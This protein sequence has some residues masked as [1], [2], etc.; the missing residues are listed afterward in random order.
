MRKAEHDPFELPRC[1]AVEQRGECRCVLGPAEGQ[2]AGDGLARSRAEREHEN[3]VLD[4]VPRLECGGL[5]LRIDRRDR[6]AAQLRSGRTHQHLEWEPSYLGDVERLGDR[7]RPVGE[8]PLGR[9]ELDPDELPSE[10]PQRK[11][12]LETC[13][14]RS[15]YDNVPRAS[16]HS[17][18]LAF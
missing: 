1:R 18:R 4:L 6:S 13:N 15:G 16:T 10:R 14:A 8:L 11:C 17:H 12:R 9:D 3:V 2:R 7:E 5:A